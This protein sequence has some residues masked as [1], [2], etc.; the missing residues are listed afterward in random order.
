VSQILFDLGEFLGSIKLTR[1]NLLKNR[2][3]FIN[4][5]KTMPSGSSEGYRRLPMFSG[6]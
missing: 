5:E 3:N 6:G 4:T 2:K 1:G